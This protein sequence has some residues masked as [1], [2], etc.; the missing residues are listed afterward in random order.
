MK[1]TILN[2]VDFEKSAF[3]SPVF[4]GQVTVE[5]SPEWAMD[6]LKGDCPYFQ[7]TNQNKDIEPRYGFKSTDVKINIAV[8]RNWLF[9]NSYNVV[10]IENN[11]FKSVKADFGDD[12]SWP[13]TAEM[14][15][16]LPTRDT[17]WLGKE[18]EEKDNGRLFE[19]IYL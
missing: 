1:T 11:N 13:L 8:F 2:I 16:D 10:E 19:V 12:L 18:A 9:Q 3:L 6:V 4:S 17:D 5:L 15:K 7:L 14:L